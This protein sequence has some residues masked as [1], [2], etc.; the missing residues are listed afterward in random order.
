MPAAINAG[1]PATLFFT[2]RHPGT[3]AL[4]TQYELEDQKRLVTAQLKRQGT[5]LPAQDVLEKENRVRREIVD[6]GKTLADVIELY[7]WE[8]K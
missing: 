4:I 5:E 2:V 1:Q 7:K 8:K 3:S 6:L